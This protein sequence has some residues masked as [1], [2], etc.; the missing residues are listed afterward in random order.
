MATVLRNQGISILLHP[1]NYLF[2]L[3]TSTLSTLQLLHSL[4]LCGI[5][6][7]RVIGYGMKMNLRYWLG[8]YDDIILSSFNDQSL[9]PN[10]VTNQYD[11][12]VN[13]KVKHLFTSNL[14][15][16]DIESFDGYRVNK[17][18]LYG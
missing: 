18:D 9:R 4:T 7:V 14:S 16:T 11:L 8:K 6:S 15:T 3:S 13:H 2:S 5:R 10:R 17:Y 1:R 12:A